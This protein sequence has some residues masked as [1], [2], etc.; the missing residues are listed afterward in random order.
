MKRFIRFLSIALF[1]ASVTLPAAAKTIFVAEDGLESGPGTD[2]ENAFSEIRFALCVAD[3][4]DTILVGPGTYGPFSTSVGMV[5]YGAV[6]IQ[7]VAGAFSTFIVGEGR[8]WEDGGCVVEFGHDEDRIVGFTIM[9]GVVGVYPH[10]L[11]YNTRVE[12]CVIRE[13]GTEGGGYAVRM[14]ILSDCLVEDCAS[15]FQGIVRRSELDRC[16]VRNNAGTGLENCTARNCLV[17]G[18]HGEECGGADDC[19]ALYNCTIVGNSSDAGTAGVTDAGA[20]YYGTG[21]QLYNCIVVEN[22]LASRRL[23]N[24]EPEVSFFHSCSYPTPAGEGNIGTA[25]RFANTTTYSLASGSVGINAGNNA[26]ALGS[27]DLEGMPRIYGGRVDMGASE[28]VAPSQVCTVHFN[29]NGGLVDPESMPAVVGSSLGILPVP[30][31]AGWRFEGWYDDPDETWGELVTAQTKASGRTMYLYAR[32]SVE[33]DSIW[34]PVYRFYSKN[35]RGHFYTIDPDERATLMCTNP[36]WRYE[37]VAYYAATEEAEGMVPLHRFYSKRYR[38]HFYTID[39]DE[40]RTVRDTNPN[41]KYE[42]VAFYVY[43]SLRADPDGTVS[44]IYRFWSKG[45]RHH[46]FTIDAD[47]MLTLRETNPNWKYEGIAF[48]AL[49]VLGSGDSPDAPSWIDVASQT[50]NG[51]IVEWEYTD[52]SEWWDIYREN[53]DDGG[54]TFVTRYYDAPFANQYWDDSADIVAGCSYRYWI[55]AC[56]AAGS[57]PCSVSPEVVARGDS[58]DGD[59][60]DAE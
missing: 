48:Y 41:W 16:I 60:F 32:W 43:P 27:Y 56:S 12:S 20:S 42:G 46:F 2:W 57:S 50:G 34:Q 59:V 18:N 17:A 53:V 4:G 55:A 25:P 35:Y 37:G 54:M 15:S 29:A 10:H 24:Y 30:Y 5:E 45:Y 28:Y 38:G 21:T 49:N 51:F 6:T 11:V 39:E 8:T 1:A 3:P 44:A 19:E 47:E 36:N 9:N 22:R 26:Y 13:C 14:A 40:M 52:G 23:S 7:S 31:R 58:N 33:T